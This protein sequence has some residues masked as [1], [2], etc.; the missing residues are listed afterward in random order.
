LP[1]PSL[2]NPAWDWDGGGAGK[3]AVV[4]NAG[5]ASSRTERLKANISARQARRRN[6]RVLAII[7]VRFD[8][9]LLIGELSLVGVGM[10]L[11]KVS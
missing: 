9:Q 11:G 1:A 2:T 4:I 8:P 3:L 5:V 7:G 6:A 10:G